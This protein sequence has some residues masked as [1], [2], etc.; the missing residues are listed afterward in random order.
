MMAAVAASRVVSSFTK[1]RPW[2][3]ST[4]VFWGGL[5]IVVVFYMCL[6]VCI[7]SGGVYGVCL[8]IYMYI[9]VCLCMYH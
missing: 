6:C 9:N 5:Y 8:N 3:G 7:H 2:V 4:C 1:R